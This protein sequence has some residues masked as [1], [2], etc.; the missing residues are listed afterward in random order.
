MTLLVTSKSAA[1]PWSDPVRLEIP[2]IDPDIAWD[3]DGTCWVHFSGLG[4]IARCRIDPTTGTVLGG[5]DGT[6][7]GTGL[8]Y[9]EAPHLFEREDTWYLV[10]AEGGT[11]RGHCVSVARGP[12]PLGPWESAPHN[13]ILS[14]RSTDS[15]IQN[16]GHADLVEATDGSWWMVL[17]GVRPR[18]TSPGFHVLGRETFLAPVQWKNGWPVIG[19]VAL[20]GNPPPPGPTEPEEVHR[21]DDF[22]A[23]V[24]AV[25]WVGVRRDARNVLLPA[26]ASGLADAVGQPRRARLVR[27]DVRRA[28]PGTSSLPGAARRSTLAPRV[29][30]GLSVYMDPTSHYDIAVSGG[31]LMAKARIG[32]IEAVVGDAPCPSG[33][34]VLTIETGPH[35]NGPDTVS[36]GF[37]D[38]RGTRS[39]AHLDGRYL[40]TEVTGGFLGRMIGMYAVGGEAAFDWFDYEEA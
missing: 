9:P 13:P 2:G 33:P 30:A 20:V 10:I 25:N 38:N 7:S 21:R 34:V 18:G 23:P 39:L 8:Q 37:E 36:L 3:G 26:D 15:P 1:G 35:R 12:S 17:L 31:R 22:D 40:A 11:E 32:S 4:G 16:T 19:E 24:L 29:E 14:H 28:S 27:P 5:P 6:W